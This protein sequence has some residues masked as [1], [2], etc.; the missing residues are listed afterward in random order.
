MEG[1]ERVQ[2]CKHGFCCRG[3]VNTTS[4]RLSHCQERTF[5]PKT[6]IRKELV[7]ILRKI[8]KQTKKK[9]SILA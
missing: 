4:P 6:F 1:H 2:V 7:R 8:N 9:V 5:I 3:T